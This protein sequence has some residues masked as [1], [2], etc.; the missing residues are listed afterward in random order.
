MKT[1]EKWLEDYHDEIFPE[2]LD[3]DLPDHIEN[4]ISG[5]DIADLMEYAEDYG[6]EM[7]QAGKKLKN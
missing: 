1:F 3:D 4:W 6:K 5:L 7:F 2:V